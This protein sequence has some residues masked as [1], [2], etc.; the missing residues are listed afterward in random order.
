MIPV[1]NIPIPMN[2]IPI[3]MNN[4]PV[5][6]LWLA[7]IAGGQGT[8]LFSYS[9][10]DR[11][12]QFCSIGPRT[13]IQDT[14]LRF[15]N[16]YGIDP[17]HI[18]IVVTNETQRALAKEQ[19]MAEFGIISSNIIQIEPD[20]DFAGASVV[21]TNFIN[22][23]DPNA[24]VIVTP[25]DQLVDVDVVF[26]SIVRSA[27]EKVFADQENN[28]VVFI[29]KPRQDSK[30][31]KELGV[32]VYTDKTS[33]TP[34]IEEFY[35]KPQG[36]LLEN[37][38]RFKDFV[39]STG[40]SVWHSSIFKTTPEFERF[41]N[42]PVKTNQLVDALLE[43]KNVYVTI[44]DFT[45]NDCGTFAE[46][47]QVIRHRTGADVVKLGKIENI[48]DEDCSHALLIAGEELE[49]NP[50]D[51]S[52]VAAVACEIGEKYLL[53]IVA[54]GK[55]KEVSAA[56]RLLEEC[57]ESFW[58]GMS[59]GGNN[60]TFNAPVGNTKFHVCFIGVDNFKVNCYRRRGDSKRGFEIF[61]GKIAG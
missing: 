60:N 20:H 52:G 30:V 10:A 32:F 12:K 25:A 34:K 7:V 16:Y 59:I 21:A 15:K 9:N 49:I 13:F 36:E 17:K 37:I 3:P 57:P 39:C 42:D 47:Y 44:N 35:E 46:L 11:P 55:N 58:N 8:R 23:I 54:F 53:M 19:T 2:N 6:N 51:I 22:D 41:A 18:V 38:V 4:I 48:E 28:T 5:E 26:L 29:G 1:D 40:I 56:A 31:I 50:H 45:W 14:I 61:G 33:S 43:K 24:R 27:I